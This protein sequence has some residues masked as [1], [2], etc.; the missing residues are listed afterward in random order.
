MRADTKAGAADADMT[1]LVVRFFGFKFWAQLSRFRGLR[2]PDAMQRD[3]RLHRMAMVHARWCQ[4]RCGLSSR[5]A[6]FA[7]RH[8]EAYT[9]SVSNAPRSVRCNS[10]EIA[11]EPVRFRLKTSG[12]TVG[13]APVYMRVRLGKLYVLVRARQGS[14]DSRLTTSDAPAVAGQALKIMRGCGPPHRVCPCRALWNP[15]SA[16]SRPD[17]VWLR[18]KSLRKNRCTCACSGATHSWVVCRG[19]GWCGRR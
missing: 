10:A 12:A 1:A 7:T 6:N 13:I 5:A 9:P 18:E 4:A 15:L 17:G 8:S 16:Q 3:T 2:R 11:Q 14:F 19:C